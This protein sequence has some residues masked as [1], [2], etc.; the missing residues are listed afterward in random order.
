MTFLD[1]AISIATD[2]HSG[3][4]DKLG[5]PYILHPIHVMNSPLLDTSEEKSAAV[6]HDV[7]ESKPESISKLKAV[8]IPSEVL[9]ALFL[10]TRDNNDTYD[11]YIKKIVDS[12][13][14]IAIKVKLADL[15]HNTSYKRLSHL[16]KPTVDR[17]VRKYS[18]A[19]SVLIPL[20]MELEPS[21]QGL[22]KDIFKEV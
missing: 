15:E 5:L 8:K 10:L 17:L 2:V 7:L 14:T 11:Q 6:L 22:L 21:S 18:K 20:L 12:R 19:K 3:E 4:K 1:L 13:N 16:D 9:D